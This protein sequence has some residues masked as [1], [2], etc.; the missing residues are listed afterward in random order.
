ME[1]FELIARESI[2]DLVQRYN[3]NGDSGRFDPMLELFAEGATMELPN[4]SYRGRAEIRAFFERV[5]K[6]TREGDR[7]AYIRHNTSTHQI[8]VLDENRA[9]GRCYYFVITDAGLDHWGRYIDEYRN[10]DGTWRFWHRKVTT[11]GAVPGAWS[12][13]AST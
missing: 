2:R 13:T 4:G 6:N 3:A 12:E 1:L 5:A 7:A 8:D 10:V 9:R 11:D